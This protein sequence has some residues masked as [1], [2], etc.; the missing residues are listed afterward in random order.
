[1]YDVTSA[2]WSI[3]IGTV[4]NGTETVTTTTSEWLWASLA[5]LYNDTTSSNVAEMMMVAA[6]TATL[7]NHTV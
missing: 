5:S 7:K 6:T 3:T 2:I 1:M 4:M